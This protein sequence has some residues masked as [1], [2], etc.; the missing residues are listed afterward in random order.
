MRTIIKNATLIDEQLTMNGDL[1]FENGYIQTIGEVEVKQDDR[2]IDGTNLYLMPAF[3]DTHTHFREPGFPEK[4][5]LETGSLAAV[6]GGYG[7]VLLMGNT[8]PAMSTKERVEEILLKGKHLDLV[9]IHQCATVTQDLEGEVLTD[10]DDIIHVTQ[11]F[12]DDG[13]GIMNDRLCLE[14]MLKI[15]SCGGT[16]I[17]HAE[18][19]YFTDIDMRLA[20]NLMT[21]RDIELAKKSYCALHLA[22]VSTKEAIKLVREAKQEGV[23]VTMEITPHHLLG[24]SQ[25]GYKVNPPLREQEDIEALIQGIRDNVVDCIGTDHAPHTKEDKAKGAPGISGIETSFAICYRV[26]VKERQISL[27]VLSQLMSSNPAKI[28]N[29]KKGRLIEGYDADLVLI[30]L[31]AVDVIKPETF[32]SKGKNTPFAGEKIY[33]KV[34]RTIVQGKT[35]YGGEA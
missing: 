3:I 5:T 6:K 16:L 17:S 29:L 13:K 14:A 18:N 35:V 21:Y 34:V 10:I 23:N 27:N 30:D 32:I 12:T 22:H 24:T 15:A 19:H 20:E 26:L 7:T 28:L 25:L 11:F 9:N 1:A 2:I 4:E 31:N 33:G 8:K